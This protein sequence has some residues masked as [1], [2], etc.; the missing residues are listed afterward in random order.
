MLHGSWYAITLQIQGGWF[1]LR[2]DIPS[3]EKFDS[4]QKTI[5]CYSLCCPLSQ[6]L[7]WRVMRCEGNSMDKVSSH[8]F[9]NF[10]DASAELCC[11]RRWNLSS[12]PLRATGMGLPFVQK[13][14]GVQPKVLWG[15]LRRYWMAS[16]ETADFGLILHSDIL[17]I[18]NM[19]GRRH[20]I[21]L[22]QKTRC[23]TELLTTGKKCKSPPFIGGS[24]VK[25]QILESKTARTRAF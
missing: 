18:P 11:Q 2:S 1:P 16:P 9:L 21:S 12:I 7:C 5:S 24:G 3:D 4:S 14:V 13:R 20:D 17:Q 6:T 8:G 25:S 19:A 22:L 23:F 10:S 15:I